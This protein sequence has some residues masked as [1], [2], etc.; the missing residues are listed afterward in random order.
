MPMGNILQHHLKALDTVNICGMFQKNRFKHW[1]YVDF[2]IILYMYIAPRL[3]HHFPG[4]HF[5]MSHESPWH[6]ECMFQNHHYKPSFC[7][8]LLLFCT[9][10]YP[11]AGP[12]IIKV[13]ILQHTLQICAVWSGPLLCVSIFYSILW[14]CKR[15][16]KALIRLCGCFAIRT[17]PKGP[18]S[19]CAAQF[20]HVH[21]HWVG[22]I[23]TQEPW[24]EQFSRRTI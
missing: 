9:C 14:F 16:P 2:F 22:P 11:R 17:C 20:V 21:S 7:A 15:T 10:T 19:H 5:T 24:F 3:G 1:F 18:F 23:L 8:F 12:Y 13:N 6:C 4:Q